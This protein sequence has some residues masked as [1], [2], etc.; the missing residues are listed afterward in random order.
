MS[1]LFLWLLLCASSFSLG[2]PHQAAG[3]DPDDGPSAPTAGPDPALAA[4]LPSKD[5]MQ[6]R[7]QRLIEA[8]PD[9]AVSKQAADF[10]RQALQALA[11]AD[12]QVARSKQL[13]ADFTKAAADRDAVKTRLATPLTTPLP[14][15]PA[16]DLAALDQEAV[17]FEQLIKDSK[18]EIANLNAMPKQRAARLDQLA[19]N[20][21][22]AKADLA[23]AQQ[24]LA[25]IG[26]SPTDTPEGAAEIVFQL[27]RSE[28]ARHTI[29]ALEA[30]Q[31]LYNNPAEA[32]RVQLARDA[33]VRLLARREKK[34][35]LY[36]ARI[37]EL[38]AAE[39]SHQVIEAAQTAAM[40]QPEALKQV[41]EENSALAKARSDLTERVNDI[42][43]LLDGDAIA[44]TAGLQSRLEALGQQLKRIEERVGAAGLSQASGRLLRQERDNIPN[45]RELELD[46][47]KHNEQLAQAQFE[48]YGYRDQRSDL[49]DV[50]DEIAET[51]RGLSEEQREA[52]AEQTRELFLTR[53]KYLD[54]LV[55]EYERYADKLRKSA[56][57]EEQL[58][59]LSEQY[60]DYINEHVLWIRSCDMLQPA[61]LQPAAGALG[62]SLSLSNWN[63]AFT[64][65]V[66]NTKRSLPEFLLGG[67]AVLV[68]I[69]RQR[70]AR[71]S[72]REAGEEAGKRSCIDFQPTLRA[73]WNTLVIALPWPV[74]VWFIGWWMESP[75]ESSEFVRS[76][77]VALRWT[78]VVFLGLEV[79]RHVCR[80]RGLAESHFEWPGAVIVQV[81]RQLQWLDVVLLPLVLW[82]IG[83][84]VQG[85]ETLWT[86]SL[87]RMLF[88]LIC[89]LV[90]FALGRVLL[91]PGSPFRAMMARKS[92]DWIVPVHNL[93]SPLLVGAPLALAVAAA[94]GYYY[95][96]YR[97]AVR[98]GETAVL[99]FALLFLGALLQRWLLLNRRRLAREQARQRRA[100]MAA[101]AAADG[102]T[103]P[104]EMPEEA[105]DLAALSEQTV[106]LLN[107]ALVVIGVVTAWF[108]WQD[109]TPALKM[110]NEWPLLPM[111]G[112]PKVSELLFLLI[113]VGG[114]YIC[115]RDV[116]ALL[117]LAVLQHLPLDAGVRYAISSLCRYVLL[118]I[119]MVL[120]AAA[121]GMHWDNVQWLVAA[122]S[123]GLGFG[124]QEIFANFV[125]GIILLFERPIRV[126]DIITL[127][128]K[129]GMVKR[130]RIRATTIMDWDRKEY[131]VPNKDLV[132]ERLLNWTLS[133]QMNRLVIEV[134]VAYGTDTTEAC[135]LMV[136]CCQENP[137]LLKDPPP[138]AVFEGFGD[139]TLKLALRCFLPDLE[140]RLVTIHDLH[141]AIDK[142]FREAG[143]EI[144]FPQ[145]DLNI[146]VVP[147]EWRSP[148]A[149]PAGSNGS[150][151]LSAKHAAGS[152]N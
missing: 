107:T 141:Q 34:L 134:G 66:S 22:D 143:I 90:A 111:E 99:V 142:K 73:A 124:L 2:L 54:D 137:R 101:A 108:V 9:D 135:R 62:W 67:A 106:K 86:S 93:W 100:Q 48:Q 60:N 8:G 130:I 113:A 91:A 55:N 31:A 138:I 17:K 51:L 13:A 6:Q 128:D 29:A 32:E 40:D 87:G 19:G 39:A 14:I 133:D 79:L 52:V 70:T 152:A 88:I 74:L 11:T 132:T 148:Q 144:A 82:A 92:E 105:V 78:A 89:V 127:G 150:N 57:V 151:G 20:L 28:A 120:S 46:H 15:D 63:K 38:R 98:L 47:A 23:A 49:A 118:A 115:V 61:D 56:A 119:G 126:G 77:A 122:I 50:E 68:L 42:S 84:E 94:L 83:L 30:E 136:E 7:L 10:Y 64:A 71:K 75:T 44:K 97:L 112:A 27:Y 81:R 96:S 145:R 43:R 139:S 37:A 53:K 80:V 5:E 4:Q 65:L 76:L 1:R 3:Q 33:E 35:E 12:A 58:S 114:T 140:F 59:E 21:H 117:E 36:R 18:Q 102:G 45:V 41:A 149:L 85:R 72:V 26:A 16:L 147:P 69:S 146:R 123:V 131:V 129:T 116:P 121:V 25:A 95:T 104:T 110:L 103:I 24:R 125:S 109:M